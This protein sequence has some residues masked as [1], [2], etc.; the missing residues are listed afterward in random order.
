MLIYFKLSM[1]LTKKFQKET[2]LTIDRSKIWP[3][4]HHIIILLLI[5]LVIQGTAMHN[6]FNIRANTTRK[7]FA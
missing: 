3:E 1:M 5:L 2:L 4:Y 6:C 7:V